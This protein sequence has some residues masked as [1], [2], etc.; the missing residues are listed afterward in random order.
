MV[1]H[2]NITTNFMILDT[3][4]VH[5]NQVVNTFTTYLNNTIIQLR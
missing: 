5:L 1:S 3:K 4:Q 2:H